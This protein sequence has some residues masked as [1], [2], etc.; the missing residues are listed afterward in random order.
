M[1]ISMIWTLIWILRVSLRSWSL[2][3]GVR[4]MMRMGRRVRRGA[5][6]RV[7]V[8]AV[9]LVQEAVAIVVWGAER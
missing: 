5:C 1:R 6:R 8:L 4:G 9:A 3:R 7:L 2:G